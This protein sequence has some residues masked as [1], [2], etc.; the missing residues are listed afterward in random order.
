[1]PN[2]WRPGYV[3]ASRVRRSTSSGQRSY[4]HGAVVIHMLS[5]RGHDGIGETTEIDSV[6]F[7]TGMR[8]GNERRHA[9]RRAREDEVSGRERHARTDV[10]YEPRDGERHFADRCVLA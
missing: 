1:R 6:H 10:G 3:P 5:I 4:Q 9:L 7:H 2:A 8:P